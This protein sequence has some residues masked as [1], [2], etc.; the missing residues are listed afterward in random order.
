MFTITQILL[1]IFTLC[2]LSI[3]LQYKNGPFDVFEK[4]RNYF[5]VYLV[6]VPV[7]PTIEDSATKIQLYTQKDNFFTNLITCHWCHI[8]EFAMVLI[9][10]NLLIPTIIYYFTLILSVAFIASIT[11]SVIEKLE[12]I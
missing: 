7:D 4:I 5:G 8:L 10:L 2:E 11:I 6:F 12:L 3:L 9:L 1:F